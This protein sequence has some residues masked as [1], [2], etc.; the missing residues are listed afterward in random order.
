MN[1]YTNTSIKVP[2]HLLCNCSSELNYKGKE[3]KR[4]DRNCGCSFCANFN[5]NLEYAGGLM[6]EVYLNKTL[7]KRKNKQNEYKKDYKKDYGETNYKKQE[8]QNSIIDALHL[9]LNKLKEGYIKDLSDASLTN[10]LR[11]YNFKNTE[12]LNTNYLNYLRRLAILNMKKVMDKNPIMSLFLSNN[13][14]NIIEGL[15]KLDSNQYPYNFCTDVY[16]TWN[17]INILKK[18]IR[19]QSSSKPSFIMTGNNFPPLFIAL[20][21]ADF[22]ILNRFFV[23]A[24]L[25]KMYLDLLSTMAF[26]NKD[27]RE[28]LTTLLSDNNM[29]NYNDSTNNDGNFILHQVLTYSLLKFIII[30]IREG[31]FYLDNKDDLFIELNKQKLPFSNYTMNETE[32]LLTKIFNIINFK[33]ITYLTN[34]T[35][36]FSNNIQPPSYKNAV[37]LNYDPKLHGSE[38]QIMNPPFQVAQLPIINNTV[39]Y[40]PCPPNQQFLSAYT[41]PI[42]SVYS[43]NGIYPISVNRETSTST[44]LCGNKRI[45]TAI[46]NH[47]L[48]LNVNGTELTLKSVIIYDSLTS[49]FNCGDSGDGVIGEA[50]L[51]NLGN[52]QWF[53]YSPRIEKYRNLIDKTQFITKE[54]I[55]QLNVDN[56]TEAINATLKLILNN[57]ENEKMNSGVFESSLFIKKDQEEVMNIIQQYSKFLFYGGKDVAQYNEIC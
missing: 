10:A 17:P 29:V 24:D 40:M 34:N 49:T 47:P 18:D 19:F 51:V 13:R 22:P 9:I 36:L 6:D 14:Q 38:Q 57:I 11:Y 8:T 25:K 21:L 16:S 32:I 56:Q 53:Y 2:V 27:N 3:G 44:V 50:A 23:S 15:N 45:N 1:C 35:D 39:Q 42:I 26:D 46:K 12:I 43:V 7:S 41:N 48:T 52:G 28:L 5:N 30:A 54:Q 55:R 31:Y 4:H 20:F 33:P 37:Y